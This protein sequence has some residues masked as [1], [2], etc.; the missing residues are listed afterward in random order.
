MQTE[1]PDKSDVLKEQLDQYKAPLKNIDLGSG[2]IQLG[3]VSII[4]NP[5]DEESSEND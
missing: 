2:E 5:D 1:L 3:N 4:I